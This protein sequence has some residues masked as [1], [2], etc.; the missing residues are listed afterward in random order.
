MRNRRVHARRT[1]T[2]IIITITCLIPQLS[3]SLS[4]SPDKL[5][6][7][8]RRT[9][10]ECKIQSID[11]KSILSLPSKTT[12]LSQ[13]K[14]FDSKRSMTEKLLKRTQSQKKTTAETENNYNDTAEKKLTI[15]GETF[16]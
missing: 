11:I 9:C 14:M 1:Y 16:S 3:A 2:R 7:S 10:E 15:Y 6:L 12:A 13:T 4:D 8:E 5:S